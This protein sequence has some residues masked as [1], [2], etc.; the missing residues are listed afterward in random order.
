VSRL[1]MINLVLKHPYEIFDL[2]GSKHFF[3]TGLWE[4]ESFQFI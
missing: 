2:F 4:V 3:S 1:S